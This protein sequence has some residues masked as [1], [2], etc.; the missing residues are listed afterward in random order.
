MI[1]TK[2]SEDEMDNVLFELGKE[3]TMSLMGE[4]KYFLGIQVKQEGLSLFL[5]Q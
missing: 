4:L 5:N 1:V 2:S 3:S